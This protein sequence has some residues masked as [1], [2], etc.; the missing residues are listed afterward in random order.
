MKN[1]IM[2][3]VGHIDNPAGISARN[4]LTA[5][6]L[7][8]YE[9]VIPV[10]DTTL[11]SATAVFDK[12]KKAKEDKTGIQLFPNPATDYTIV[13]YTM[14]GRCIME[15]LSQD[16]RLIRTEN[17]KRGNNQYLLR[18]GDLPSGVYTLKLKG[19]NKS[20]TTKLVIR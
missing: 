5:Y 9:A 19:S 10:P 6:R 1:E 7:M 18:T 12:P 15:L 13:S 14:E 3:K 16:G 4:L 2:F 11:K 20:L 8:N 17:L